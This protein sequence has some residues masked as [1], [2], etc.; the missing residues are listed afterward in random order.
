MIEKTRPTRP[1]ME[2]I[3]NQTLTLEWGKLM[4]WHWYEDYLRQKQ[5]GAT[6]EYLMEEFE[7]FVEYVMWPA[8]KAWLDENDQRQLEIEIDHYKVLLIE[9]LGLRKLEQS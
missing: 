9:K 7:F 2:E 3:V 5:A 8:A 6:P 1:D 4:L